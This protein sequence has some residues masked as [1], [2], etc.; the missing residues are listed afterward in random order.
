MTH[1]D[2]FRNP[3]FVATYWTLAGDV[4]PLGSPEQEAS[5]HDFRQRVAVAAELGYT[6]LG[7]MRSDLANIRRHYDLPTM[8]RILAEYG[9]RHLELEFLVGWIA[10]GEEL[11][12]SAAAFDELLAAARVLDVRH[13][14]VGPDMNAKVWPMSHMIERFAMLCRRAAEVGTGIVIEPMPWSNI[15]DLESAVALVKGA[16]EVN[17]GL[18]IDIWHMARGG[19]AYA[20]VAALPSGLIHHVELDDADETVRGTLLE[21]TLDHRRHCGQGALD[22]PAFIAALERQGYNGPFG[23]EIISAHERRRPFA[24][25]ARDAIACARQQFNDATRNNS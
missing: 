24:D 8:K 22:V 18:L 7:L 25:V 2:S 21:D 15:A 23:I 1:A 11:A 12:Q 13:I 17:G 16:G 19:I 10:D 14:K 20:D 4:V 5:P 6:G 9:M 3:E